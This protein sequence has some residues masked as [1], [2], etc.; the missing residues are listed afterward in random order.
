MSQPLKQTGLTTCEFPIMCST[1]CHFDITLPAAK[2]IHLY[3]FAP[4]IA[5][6]YRLRTSRDIKMYLIVNDLLYKPFN[7]TFGSWLYGS[8]F[9][10][11]RPQNWQELSVFVFSI[12]LSFKM[13]IKQHDFIPTLHASAWNSQ[14]YI[15]RSC[16]LMRLFD[17]SSI[18]QVLRTRC[19]LL[20]A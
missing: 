11:N 9:P 7:M 12:C 3:L 19:T 18:N 2:C 1:S 13:Y 15:M 4:V 16:W 8:I 10:P 5:L 17:S 20:V 14:R 6:Q